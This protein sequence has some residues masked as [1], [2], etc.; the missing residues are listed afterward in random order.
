M[1]TGDDLFAS[2]VY[3]FRESSASDLAAAR[4]HA[5]EGSWS[6]VERTAHRLKGSSA[7]LGVARVASVCAG[8]EEQARASR[9]HEIAP[10]L[11]RLG[12][13]L[14]DAWEALEAL[15]RGQEKR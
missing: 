7:A 6:E 15:S 13:E 14:E 12:R 5:E 11:R 10:L 4:Q 3:S 9:T 8:I 2:L 1:F